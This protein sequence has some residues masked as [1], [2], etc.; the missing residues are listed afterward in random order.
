VGVFVDAPL[1]TVA[2]VVERA[3]LR[4]VQLHGEELPGYAA[5]V[6]AELVIK[7]FR[8]GRGFRAERMEEYPGQLILLDAEVP[9]KAGGTGRTCDWNAARAAARRRPI[10]LAGGL[11]GE[12]V[13]AAIAAV[14][15][16]GI[17]VAS[18]VEIEPGRK[19]PEKVRRLFQEVERAARHS[20]RGQENG[21]K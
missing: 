11:S 6:R 10:L 3:G 12:N 17:D 8:A 1:E 21:V 14:L 7:A 19:D 5:A 4:G 15:P 13:E 2:D 16:E 20:E 18:G 9:G